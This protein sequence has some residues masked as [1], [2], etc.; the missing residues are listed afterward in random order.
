[1]DPSRGKRLSC[2]TNVAISRPV[3]QFCVSS[4]VAADHIALVGA[5]FTVPVLEISSTMIRARAAAGE[6]VAGWVP[7][8]VADYIVA[9]QLYVE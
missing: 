7:Q 9:S 6:S 1:M 2:L 3:S 4:C 8:P 5:V